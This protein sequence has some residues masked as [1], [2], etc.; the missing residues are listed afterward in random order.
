[1]LIYERL[2]KNLVGQQSTHLVPRSHVL[3]RCCFIRSHLI[4]FLKQP[5]RIENLNSFIG[6]TPMFIGDGMLSVL[7]VKE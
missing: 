6:K 1:V 5:S 4:Y 7:T 3:F 2:M